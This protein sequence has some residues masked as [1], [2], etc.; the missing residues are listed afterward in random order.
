MTAELVGRKGRKVMQERRGS[1]AR[2][3]EAAVHESA[4]AGITLDRQSERS[5]LLPDW[6]REK[7]ILGSPM[8]QSIRDS[9]NSTAGPLGPFVPK[10]CA[11]VLQAFDCTVPSPEAPLPVKLPSMRRDVA[12][13][14]AFKLTVNSYIQEPSP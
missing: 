1:A 7:D 9:R 4:S 6:R 5:V 13:A 14:V 11:I 3:N 2:I 10:S 12:Q 8:F